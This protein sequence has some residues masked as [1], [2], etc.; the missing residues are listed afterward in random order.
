MPSKRPNES[1]AT[2][3]PM[4]DLSPREQILEYF[5][6]AH[7]NKLAMKML[8]AERGVPEADAQRLAPPPVTETPPQPTLSPFDDDEMDEGPQITD[9]DLSPVE[10][11]VGEAADEE[12]NTEVPPAPAAPVVGEPPPEAP[13][14]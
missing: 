12:G 8:K 5:V 4:Q 10:E 14:E 2:A 3:P 1:L 11:P 13:V 9:L 7:S 6:K